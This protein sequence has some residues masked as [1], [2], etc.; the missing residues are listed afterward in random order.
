MQ[1][2][3]IFVIA[4]LILIINAPTLMSQTISKTYT[5][6]S[7]ETV[8]ASKFNTNFDTVYDGVNSLLGSI[9]VSSGNLTISGATTL[10]SIALS[11]AATFNSIVSISSTAT[12]YAGNRLF[13]HKYRTNSRFLGENAGNL[14][15][16]GAQDNT[17]IGYQALNSL[18]SGDYNTATGYQALLTNTSASYN[19]ASGYQV[20]YSNTSGYQNTASGYQALYSNTT[21]SYNTASGYQALYSNTT[22]AS[23]TASG[24]YA[25]RYNT[26]GNHNTAFGDS[27]LY[28][29][30]TG[31]YNVASG[32][33]ALYS[34]TTGYQNTASGRRALYS[35]RLVT[36]ISL[37]GTKL[38]KLPH[39]GTLI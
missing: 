38:F 26:T 31:Y 21:G 36:I 16:S 27:A 13:M 7:G 8:S 34:N 35:I 17:G 24:Y 11:G 39:R 4:L 14:T 29:N 3:K 12:V 9:T 37:Q 1:A 22:G 5:F 6:A 23:N 30:T 10:N 28:S 19:T 2:S 25:L 33:H 20:L 32:K 18:T 15:Q